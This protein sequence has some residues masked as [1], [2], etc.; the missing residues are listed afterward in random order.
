MKILHVNAGN[1]Y[2]GGLFHIVSLFEA[3]EQA[4]MDLLVFEEGPVA[5]Y[6]REKG[7]NVFTLEQSSRYDLMA[8][9]KLITF[10]E[11]REYD[12]VHTHGPRANVFLSRVYKKL[13]TAKWVLTLHSDPLLDFK[14]R[15]LKGKIFEWLNLKALPRTDHIIAVSREIRKIAIDSGVESSKVS[16]VH[17]GIRPTKNVPAFNKQT[18]FRISVVGRLEWV[19]GYDYLLKALKEANLSNWKL[20]VYGKG[21]QESSLKSQAE[22]LAI[23]ENVHFNGWIEKEELLNHLQRSEIF[24]VSSISESFPLVAL[25]AGQSGLALIAT[26]VGDVKE[27]VPTEEY[28]WLIP[29]QNVSALAKALQQAYHLWEQNKLHSKRRS[30]YEWTKQFS[31]KK[32]AEETYTVYKN[33]GINA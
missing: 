17:N 19:K 15:G 30:F 22:E 10:I 9:K 3:M 16:V 14:G 4:D 29:A 25:E 2:G 8:L 1:E 5:E 20:E 31:I 27:L 24:V 23:Q 7:I 6:A 18:V 11:E 21:S 28:G 33:T 12:V 13:T 26:E 32:Q